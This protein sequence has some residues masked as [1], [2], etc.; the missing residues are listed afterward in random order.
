MER[1]YILIGGLFLLFVL[2][3]FISRLRTAYAKRK[4]L[5]RTEEQKLHD[6]NEM[7]IPFGY[8]YDITQDIF[9][10]ILHPWQR[11][12]GYSSLYDESAISLGMVIHCEPIEFE[13]RGNLY[14]I[15][16]WKGQ[17]G[18]TVGA[19]VGIYRAEKPK[20]YK[21]GDFVFY[22]SISDEEL[23][24]ISME[25]YQNG[26]P[27]MKRAARHWWLTS[28]VL[29]MSATPEELSM[30]VCITFPNY[31]MRT[32]FLQAL[33]EAGYCEGDIQLHCLTVSIFFGKP[34]TK[35]PIRKWKL[36]RKITAGQNRF[37]CKCYFKLTDSF[38]STLDR[39]DFL[40]YRYRILFCLILRFGRLNKRKMARIKKKFKK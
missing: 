22:Q 5:S 27:I 40:R 32:A 6:L 8:C 14:L 7:I 20:D 21:K 28:F 23:L 19:E 16:L 34:K 4:V 39:I 29:G 18:M 10:T 33:F 11:E 36:L 15:E 13:Y 1:I 24:P 2:C 3:L 35:Q 17:Y 12:M 31:T 26:K 38:E 9:T 37:F 30:A 25:V